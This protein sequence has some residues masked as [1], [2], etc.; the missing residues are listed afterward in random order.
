MSVFMVIPYPI[1]SGKSSTFNLDST[2]CHCHYYLLAFLEPVKFNVKQGQLVSV[3]SVE[4]ATTYQELYFFG[5]FFTYDF[6]PWLMFL[7]V[8]LVNLSEPRS[9]GA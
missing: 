8:Y 9:L 2:S 3:T 6:N 5:R 7:D 4:L 1:R